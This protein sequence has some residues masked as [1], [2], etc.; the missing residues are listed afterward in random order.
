MKKINEGS[1]PLP[2]LFVENG[3]VFPKSEAEIEITDIADIA[4]ISATDATSRKLFIM[5]VSDKKALG[6]AVS[7]ENAVEIAQEYVDANKTIPGVVCEVTNIRHM[8]N[9]KGFVVTF[10]GIVAATITDSFSIK[11]TPGIL[12]AQVNVIFDDE[13]SGDD[14]KTAGAYRRRIL[15]Q[16]KK[17][18]EQRNA[19]GD[20]FDVKMSLLRIKDPGSFAFN[21]AQTL[22]LEQEMQIEILKLKNPIE[23]LAL[24]SKYLDDEIQYLEIEQEVIVKAT[25]NLSQQQ[26]DVFLREQMHVIEEELGDDDIGDYNDLKKLLE[27]NKEFMAAS[28]YEKI[29][30]ELERM[31]KMSSMSADYPVARQHLEFILEL[32]WKKN[33]QQPIELE[34]IREILDRDH[35]GLEKVKDRIVEFMAV[36]TMKDATANATICLFGPPGTG[37]TSVVRSISEALGREYVRISLGGVRDEAEIRGHRKTYVGA[38]AGRILT[39]IEKAKTNNPVILLDEID[40]LCGDF[41][42]DPASALLEVLDKE[43]NKEFVDTYAEV[44]YDLSDVL[45]ITTANSLE[46]IPSPLLDRLEVI[47]LSSYTEKEKYEIAVRHL[48][49]KQMKEH[50]LKK[51]SV[52]ISDD[53][54]YALI[55]EYTQE[56]GVRSLERQIAAIMRKAICIMKTQGKKTVSVNKKTLLDMLGAGRAIHRFDTGKNTEFVGTVNGLAWTSVGGVLLSV[57]VNV[58]EGTGK[59]EITGLI[60]DVMK[61]SATAAMSY[62]RSRYKDFGIESDFYKTKDIHIHLPE[63]ATPKDGPS[64]GVS[65]TTAIVSALTGIPVKQSVAMTGEITIRGEVLAI[66]G[67]KEKTLA[68]LKEGISTVVVPEENKADL[69]ELPDEVKNGL[70][71][72]TVKTVDEVLDIAL[73][74]KTGEK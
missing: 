32:P 19:N 17:Y 73:S 20:G 6:D 37:K 60:G 1:I 49:P 15:K 46:T 61:E 40:K 55:N 42:G 28:T 56:A 9:E 27:K 18:A 34:K 30:K 69:R 58:L 39:A 29:S 25:D 38:M 63:G 67:L 71:I 21:I 70:E 59:L 41:R 7:P 24:V 4:V 53:A 35:Y 72:I 23:R 54:V 8:G 3:F 44:P 51:S 74:K 31:R 62:I 66:G 43:Q 22:D 36:K 5:P 12:H 2:I 47:E 33:E 64:A 52:K 48:I 45:F 57:Q 68:A 10:Y 65:L 11:Q 13:I 26:K 14:E 50:G 16:Y